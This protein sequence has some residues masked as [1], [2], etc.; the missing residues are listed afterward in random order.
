VKDKLIALIENA[1]STAR[2]EGVLPAGKAVSVEIEETK[3]ETHGDFACNI[4]MVSAPI[5]KMAPRK[6]AETIVAHINDSANIVGDIQIAGPGFINFFV[7]AS[8][9]L[10]LL[11]RITIDGD[12]FGAVDIGQNRKVQVEFVSANPT[13]PLHVG[14]GRGAAVGDAIAR[15]LAFSGFNVQKEYYV[16]D[17][18]RQIRTLGRS[19][20]L[21]Y[22]ELHGVK[23]PFPEDCYKGKYIADLAREMQSR[24]GP[25]LL[26][27]PEK[28]AIDLCARHGAK[29]L[30]AGIKNDL[31]AFDIHFDCWFS[32]QSLYDTNKVQQTIDDFTQ[33][34][35]I[36]A[37]DG[38]LWFKTADH[39]DEKDRVVVKNS[40]LTTYFASDIA[41]HY[42]KYAR[43][44]EWVIDVWGADHHGYIPRVR[45]A[46]AAG[47]YH[48][49]QFDVILVQLVHLLRDGKPVAMSTRKGEFV[50]LKEVIDEVGVDAARFIFLSRG[51][52]SPLD[53]DLTRA[54]QKTNDNPVYYVQYVHARITSILKKAEQGNIDLQAVPTRPLSQPDE[55][56]LIKLLNRF[57]EI[58]VRAATRLAPHLVTF[59]LMDLAGAF[60][61]FYNKHRVLGNDPAMTKSRVRLIIA[62]RQVLKNGLTL[63]GVAAPEVM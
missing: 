49:E 42:N 23:A 24:H 7:A 57:P 32:E 40:G 34:G 3:H 28:K 20:F 39:H 5:F 59:Y 35:V 22:Q 41:Y 31:A 55:L 52:D 50:T 54:V 44:L 17:S 4:A 18:G 60:H 8:A 25:E 38:A 47:G 13:G 46:I 30:L 1:V 51:S 21:R 9:W 10:P 61:S 53:F 11:E 12:R 63:L 26:D 15:I 16:N 2:T 37:H 6:I 43:G 33:K 29:I 56:R 48:Q 36:Y 58:V 19:V 14:H 62:T 27:M 45:A